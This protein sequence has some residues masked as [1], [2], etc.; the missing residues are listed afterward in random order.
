M[1]VSKGSLAVSREAMRKKSLLPVDV[2]VPIQRLRFAPA[3]PATVDEN[4]PVLVKPSVPVPIVPALP[5]KL[6]SEV[7]M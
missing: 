2:G 1:T 5:V 3:A 7:L 6:A 4:A